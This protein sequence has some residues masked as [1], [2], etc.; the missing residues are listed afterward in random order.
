MNPVQKFLLFFTLSFCA[1]STGQSVKLSE[2]AE[3]S[4][5]TCGLGNEM[6]SLFGHTAIRISDPAQHLDVVYNYGAFDF[7]TPNFVAKFSKG[8]LQY[9]VT[10]D[11]FEDFMYAYNYEQRS[12]WEQQL[13]MTPSQKQQLLDELNATMASEKRF[14][15]YKFIDRNCTTMVADLINRILGNEV[16]TK[17]KNTDLTYREVLYPYFDNHFYEQLGTSIIF[18]TKVDQKAEKIFLPI[19]LLQSIEVAQIDGSPLMKQSKTWMEYE[20]PKPSGR[21]WNNPITYFVLVML[22]V[23]SKSRTVTVIYW[24]IL[25]AIGL[26]FSVAGLYSYHGELGSN[27]NALLFNPLLLLM[28]YFMLRKNKRAIYYTSIVL[29]ACIAIY[30]IWMLNK[31]HLIIVLPVLVAQLVLLGRSIIDS[32]PTV[33]LR[34]A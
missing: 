12:V 2:N 28:A 18:G 7:N 4:V 9:F 23:V 22:V 1:I 10:S 34:P 26:F 29:I 30:I 13:V 32:K 8:D 24:L 20:V 31:I 17:I 33:Q 6:Y 19:E 11:S 3:V 16:L 21:W 14:Y 15:T 27:Y 5:L 25:G